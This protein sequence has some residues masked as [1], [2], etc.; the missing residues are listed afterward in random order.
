M[1]PHWKT[2]MNTHR[3]I[4]AKLKEI[5]LKYDLTQSY[6]AKCIGC[7]VSAVGK[8]EN[9]HTGSVELIESVLWAFGLEMKDLH[10]DKETNMISLERAKRIREDKKKPKTIFV[11]AAR[12]RAIAK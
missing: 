8:V 5:R 12:K 9:G 3:R 11:K 2:L 4:G 10:L 6:V 1:V 7:S